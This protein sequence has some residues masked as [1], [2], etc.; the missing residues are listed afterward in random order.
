MVI[1]FRSNSTHVG[2]VMN[3]CMDSF[4]RPRLL[5]G[6]LLRRSQFVR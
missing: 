5:I 4:L 2:I 6:Y 1:L 3:D